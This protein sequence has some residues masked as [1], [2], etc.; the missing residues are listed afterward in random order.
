MALSPMAATAAR[1]SRRNQCILP[2]LNI[3]T[4]VE[5]TVNVSPERPI[6]RPRLYA[7]FADRI[8]AAATRA[9][10]DQWR[11]SRAKSPFGLSLPARMIAENCGDF[12]DDQPPGPA[13][14]APFAGIRWQQPA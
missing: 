10:T 2:C 12:A 9:M 1:P 3:A 13:R 4:P 8:A 7:I 11:N 14:F 6:I 5:T